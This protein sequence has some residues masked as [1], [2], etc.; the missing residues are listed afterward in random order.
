[1]MDITRFMPARRKA[2]D[3]IVF[4]HGVNTRK[5]REAPTY[6]DRL[7]HLLEERK[8]DLDLRYISLYWGDAHQ[9]QEQCL[10]D[11][12]KKD[13]RLWSQ[14]FFRDVREKALLQ[15]VGDGALFISRYAGRVVVDLLGQQLSEQLAEHGSFQ[16]GLDRLHLVTHSFGTVIFFDMLFSDRWYISE[17]PEYK[18]VLYP[19][20]RFIRE[21]VF[22]LPPDGKAGLDLCSIHTMGSPISIYSLIVAKSLCPHQERSLPT[23]E[24][25][26]PRTRDIIPALETLLAHLRYRPVP[27]YNYLHPGDPVAQPL[28]HVMT[29]V[30]GQGVDKHMNI[31]DKLTDQ[32]RISYRLRLM[33]D[34]A[35]AMFGEAGQSVSCALGMSCCHGSYWESQEVAD[36]IID[37][38]HTA[39]HRIGSRSIPQLV[40]PAPADA[41]GESGS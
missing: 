33:R 35:L 28:A 19:G 39:S 36:Q 29:Q 12:Y 9:E 30:L 25:W 18:P 27:W 7:R 26:L 13:K 5:S 22:G 15:F 32:K 10:L 17:P 8:A 20:I 31:V 40:Q 6:A 41:R 11:L 37:T 1:M 38:I 16:S 3:F 23:G 4:I 24:N 21:Q 14:L 2:K 34:R